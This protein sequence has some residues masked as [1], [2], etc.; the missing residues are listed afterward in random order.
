MWSV[1]SGS[2]GYGTQ[3]AGA[4][5]LSQTSS[6][7]RKA[8]YVRTCSPPPG[9]RCCARLACRLLSSRHPH[10]WRLDCR[11]HCR[12]AYHV[13]RCLL[14]PNWARPPRNRRR[15]PRPPPHPC[16]HLHRWR[17][18]AHRP[19]TI[20]R[21]RPHTQNARCQ[22]LPRR[23]SARGRLPPRREAGA[24]TTQS[25]GR[26]RRTSQDRVAPRGM[27]RRECLVN[28]KCTV[29][30]ASS[31]PSPAGRRRDEVEPLTVER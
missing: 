12:L 17:H 7:Y 14:R 23:E 28:E 4:M 31:G 16:H 3:P 1:E 18:R 13:C 21:P 29:A 25:T 5:Q 9:T 8:A 30:S 6:C 15:L 19:Q 2:S 10:Q 20:D 24:C 26:R 27:H 11:P 22:W